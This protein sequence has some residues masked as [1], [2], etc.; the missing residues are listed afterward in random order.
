MSRL[1]EGDSR[2]LMNAYHSIYEGYGKGK[3]KIMHN[4]ATH[5]EHSEYGLGNCIKEMHTLDEEGNVSH[6]DVE[7]E[8]GIVENV[9]VSELNILVSEEHPHAANKMKNEEVLGEQGGVGSTSR[10]NF[11]DQQVAAQRQVQQRLA[12]G[13][14]IKLRDANP[15]RPNKPFSNPLSGSALP[16]QSNR[17]F[18]TQL[19]DKKTGVTRQGV[20]VK[21]AVGQGRGFAGAADT[22]NVA[23]QTLYKAKS[24]KDI[25]YLQGKDKPKLFKP[26]AKPPVKD[27][28]KDKGTGTGTDTPPAAKVPPA[29]TTVLAKQGGVEGKLDK[30]TGKFTAGAFTGA[31]KT[32]YDARAPKPATPAAKPSSYN[33]LMQKTFGYQTGAAPDQVKGSAA[34]NKPEIQTPKPAAPVSTSAG[35]QRPSGTPS[36]SSAFGQSTIG[37]ASNLKDTGVQKP[38]AAIAAKPTQPPVAPGYQGAKKPFGEEVDAYDLVLDYLLENGHADT[39]DE[40]HYVM[41]EM[42]SQMIQDIVEVVTTTGEKAPKAVPSQMFPNAPRMGAERPFEKPFINPSGAPFKG[43]SKSVKKDTKTA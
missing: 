25:V 9:P 22:V 2:G 26:Q 6:Y 39:V 37:A 33:P 27:D 42:D 1:T 15:L 7:F 21:N 34:F 19:T 24:G 23:G 38:T 5:V 12:S 17:A 36:G 8:H 40:A 3:K 13:G 29:S 20:V 18:G 32:R 10:P 28:P 31:E 11:K 30:S 4:C 41:L 43:A 35:F 14:D 16:N